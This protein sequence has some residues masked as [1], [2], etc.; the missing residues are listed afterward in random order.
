MLVVATKPSQIVNPVP[1][2]AAT[3]PPMAFTSME[4]NTASTNAATTV[5]IHI[6]AEEPARSVSLLP[7][8]YHQVLKKTAGL[9]H[10][11]PM[12]MLETTQAT[13]ANQFTEEKSIAAS[14]D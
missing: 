14:F 2:P 3:V 13:T 12:T 6:V 7:I 10:M 11:E 8:P 9:Y 1:S 4:T 5:R